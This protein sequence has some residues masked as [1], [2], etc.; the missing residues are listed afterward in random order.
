MQSFLSF[1]GLSYT[2]PDTVYH[3]WK[4]GGIIIANVCKELANFIFEDI[5][6]QY[7]IS[8]FK[9]TWTSKFSSS[10]IKHYTVIFVQSDDLNHVMK[11]TFNGNTKF[12]GNCEKSG[13]IEILERPL[14]IIISVS[15]ICY[16]CVGLLYWI[17][18]NLLLLCVCALMN[19]S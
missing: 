6:G 10:K 1:M 16:V 9:V 14:A 8:M 7:N 19:L 4:V 3:C 18:I 12:G 11:K 17:D 2:C 15:H 5:E 13:S